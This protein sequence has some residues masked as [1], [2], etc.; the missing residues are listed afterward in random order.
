[1]KSFVVTLFSKIKNRAI[2]A[3]LFNVACF[4]GGKEVRVRWDSGS[5]ILPSQF[6][7]LWPDKSFQYGNSTPGKA[8][9]LAGDN[10]LKHIDFQDGDR[11]IDCGANIGNPLLCRDWRGCSISYLAFEP[12]PQ[13]YEYQRKIPGYLVGFS[14]NSNPSRC[15]IVDGARVP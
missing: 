9:R 15:Q 5:F 1:M 2:A 13:E 14:S 6:R 12:R 3:N 8:E 7:Y 10:L 4:F 11:V